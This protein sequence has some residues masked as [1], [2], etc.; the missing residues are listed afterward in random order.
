MFDAGRGY[1]RVVPSPI[2]KRIIEI[3]A[4]EALT[5]KGFCVIGA[6]GGGIPVY[7]NE[8]GEIEGVDAVIETSGCWKA[9]HQAIR[10]CASGYGRVVALGF[11]QGQGEDLYLGHEFHHSSFYSM[12]ASS[13]LA[14]NHRLNPAPGRAWDRT[15]VYRYSAKMLADKYLKTE[16]LLTCLFDFETSYLLS[17]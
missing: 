7:R 8:D 14:I 5:A 17:F 13:I 15:R 9:L 12:G 16:G 3:D 2:P 6:G 4:I 1:R 10:C 11:Y